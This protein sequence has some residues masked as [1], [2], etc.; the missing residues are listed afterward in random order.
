M[1]PE[2]PIAPGWRTGHFVRQREAGV[3]PKRSVAPGRRSC[4]HKGKWAGRMVSK[5]RTHPMKSR[6]LIKLLSAE[7]GIP[8]Y[9]DPARVVW[10]NSK[11]QIHRDFGPATDEAGT[12]RWYRNGIM[13][14]EDGPAYTGD[15]GEQAWYL[16]GEIHREDGPA[17]VRPD[18]KQEWW[19][20]GKRHREDGPA[21]VHA[22]GRQHW[23]RNGKLHR[24]DGPAAIHRDGTRE[25]YRNDKLH[26]KDGPAVIRDDGSEEWWINGRY[27]MPSRWKEATR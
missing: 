19:K 2:W 16:N 14:R 21:I 9:S 11:G 20:N 4:R 7:T 8:D 27:A 1:V 25:W 5:R 17:V 10:R 26:R 12:R 24:E 6:D 13:H 18:G 3:V 23:F 15:D 22:D